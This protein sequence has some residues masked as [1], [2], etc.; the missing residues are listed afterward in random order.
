MTK[1]SN[2]SSLFGS[3]SRCIMQCTD[4][5]AIA[6]QNQPAAPPVGKIHQF[7]K[8]AVTFEPIPLCWCP[9]RFTISEKMS[10]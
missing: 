9:S 4:L 10:I 3:N 7:S 1:K 6:N 2:F 5:E 8:I